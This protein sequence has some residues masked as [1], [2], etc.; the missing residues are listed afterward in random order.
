MGMDR[1]VEINPVMAAPI[2]AIWPIGC[3]AIERILP[4]TKPKQ[5][6]ND[7]KK[8]NKIGKPGFGLPKN[9]IV[10]NNATAVKSNKAYSASFRIPK[11][12]TKVP[13]KNVEHPIDM[14]NPAKM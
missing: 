6:N 3:M 13:F 1:M 14:A 10:Y 12:I 11:R 5:K 9:N 2:P 7:A 8:T 4:Q